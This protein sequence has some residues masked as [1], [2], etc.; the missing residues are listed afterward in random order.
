ML[1]TTSEIRALNNDY[2]SIDKTT[3]VLSFPVTFN[4]PED[5]PPQEPKGT[6]EGYK[7]LDLKGMWE[8]GL[9]LGDV[10]IC[11]DEVWRRMEEDKEFGKDGVNE[12]ENEIGCGGA[13]SKTDRLD[14][15][16]ELLLIH[17]MAHLRGY[18]HERGEG[19]RLLQCEK[20]QEII[21]CT[22]KNIE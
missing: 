21:Q 19:D 20:E 18:D 7:E 5:E 9:V 11:V 15:R 12:Q 6:E 17:A 22:L 14:K 10:A 8:E 16:I 2:R 1:C 4:Y 13:I 3:D